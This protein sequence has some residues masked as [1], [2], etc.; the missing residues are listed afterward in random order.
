ML[1]KFAHL[2]NFKAHKRKLVRTLVYIS[3]MNIEQ[4]YICSWTFGN[5]WLV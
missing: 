3:Y 1:K 4:V 5:L 2:P